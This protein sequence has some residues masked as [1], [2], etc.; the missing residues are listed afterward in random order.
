M[1]VLNLLVVD[2]PA[3][4]DLSH[5]S[6]EVVSARN[7]LSHSRF[8]QFRT[9]ARV[10]NLCRSY[11]YQSLGYY[12]SLL[13]EARGHRA[14]PDVATLRDFRSSAIVRARGS[15]WDAEIQAALR[16]VEGDELTL[17]LVFG[18]DFEQGAGAL[19]SR[20][21]RL[22]PSPLLK[23]Q[24]LRRKSTWVIAGVTPLSLHSFAGEERVRVNELV[25][26]F[27]S[28]R[29]I[30]VHPRKKFLYDLAIVVD[31]AEI[32]PPSDQKALE[33]FAVAAREVGFYTETITTEDV[34]RI[35]EFDAV[36]IRQGTAVDRPI[37]QLSRL[38]YAEGLAVIDDP[39]SILRCTNKIY[40]SESLGRA[41]IATPQTWILTREDLKESG[42][43]KVSF[44]CV[45]KIPDGSFSVGVRKVED[46]EELIEVLRGMLG[47]SE[48]ILAQAFVP[49]EYDWRIGV[50]DHQPLFAC[51]YFMAK[52][53]WQIYNWASDSEKNR[54]GRSE[55][56]YV[57]NVPRIVMETA[58]RAA[59]L[60]GDGLYGVDLKQ[61][62]DEVLVIEI[63][64]NPSI[65][66]GVEDKLIGMEL[67]RRIARS[68]RRRVDSLRSGN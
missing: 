9:G 37:Y 44:P 2:N 22:F 7:Y 25:A 39:W 28:K 61:V 29:Q 24:F 36:F 26:K 49:S 60:V 30:S 3:R 64:D 63:N 16:K 66:V 40:L 14:V 62:A 31:P 45:L 58:L 54:S 33:R 47:Q 46:R 13:A 12:V 50:L 20:L 17:R 57:D 1:P 55:T 11:N 48:L 65:E 51:R 34:D 67:Y 10:F 56:F 5:D 43:R 6:V 35:K 4:W 18:Q 68:F 27:F 41:K 42:A 32:A 53:H 19:G 52:D 21:Y 23:V 15:E 59:R 8:Q 38:A